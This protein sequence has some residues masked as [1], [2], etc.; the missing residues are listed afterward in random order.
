MVRSFKARKPGTAKPAIPGQFQPGESGNPAGRPKGSRNQRTVFLHSLLDGDAEAI[1]AKLVQLARAGDPQALRLATERLLPARERVAE[2]L[3][4]VV[5]T[6]ED[7]SGAI[8]G[9]IRQAAEGLITVET[10]SAF[11][12]FLDA[13]RKAIE[14]GELSRR[15]LE[16][17][18]CGVPGADQLRELVDRRRMED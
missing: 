6:A 9:V 4:P 12:R 18:Q 7:V 10:A 13:Q 2:V 16:L 5:A 14:T 17:E 3:L 11:L 15:L 1:V 8:A